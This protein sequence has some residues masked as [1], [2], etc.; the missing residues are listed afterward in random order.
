MNKI[1]FGLGVIL[2][3]INVLIGACQT[4]PDQTTNSATPT[5]KS[6]VYTNN[7]K[8][9]PSATVNP[10]TITPC[11]TATAIPQ[12]E[13]PLPTLPTIYGKI[14][15]V[16]IE[17]GKTA[18]LYLMEANRGNEKLLL[19]NVGKYDW[20]PQNNLI[21]AVSRKDNDPILYL[22][23]I[24]HTGARAWEIGYS[25]VWSPTNPV[26]AYEA[27]VNGQW[28]LYTRNLGWEWSLYTLNFGGDS[29]PQKITSLSGRTY[30]LPVWSPDG[31]RI[32][33][34]DQI[35]EK[36]NL[37]LINADGSQ[38]RILAERVDSTEEF[39]WSPDGTKLGFVSDNCPY[40]ANCGTPE[41]I[42]VIGSDGTGLTRLS[43]KDEFGLYPVWSP[44]GS[45][46][47]FIS[48]LGISVMHSD[49]SDQTHLSQV[50]EYVYNPVWSPDG[51]YF[52]YAIDNAIYL[53]EPV[54]GA[55]VFQLTS[56][57]R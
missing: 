52:I 4:V 9:L 43:N 38:R 15:Y 11:P 17:C 21:V 32:A 20:S 12:T 49:G 34:L 46:I 40:L 54:P 53:T 24:D 3:C 18:D 33:F 39:V 56:T 5:T 25:P 55:A 44:D 28:G 13:I 29:I 47:L 6:I 8:L 16:A 50:P 41:G 36:A 57:P 22:V 26:I 2:F 31:S 42:F 45:R 1:H 30:S 48:R 23:P 14:A 19:S 27:K 10:R 35:N 51:K 7:S 37:Y